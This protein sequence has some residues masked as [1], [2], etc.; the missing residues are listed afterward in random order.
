MADAEWSASG[1]REF[2]EPA[3]GNVLYAFLMEFE[4]IDPEG[5][6]YNPLYFKLTVDGTEYTWYLF[7]KEPELGSGDL[8]AG[9][10]IQGWLTFEAPLVDS[11]VLRYEAVGGLVGDPVEWTVTVNP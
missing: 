6:S 7:G 5:S 3:E 2:F 11:V 9:E 4:G 10:T 8:A 1:Y